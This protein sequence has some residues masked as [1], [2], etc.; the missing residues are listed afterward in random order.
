MV[1]LYNLLRGD[2]LPVVMEHSQLPAQLREETLELFRNGAAQVIVSARS[3]IEGFNVPEADL[4][5]IVA[6]SSSPR[7]RI[8]SIGRVLRTYRNQFGETKTSRVCIL[9]VRNSVDE[10][11]YER[12]DWDDL[13]GLDRNR[14]FYWNPPEEPL[15]VHS[16]PRTAVPREED[17][18]FGVLS[19]GDDYPG[20]Y[21]GK[22]FSSDSQGNVTD[23]EGQVAV[24]P[25]GIPQL[26]Q[27][28][29]GQPGRFRVTAKNSAVLVRVQAGGE[30]WTTVYGGTLA[31]PFEFVFE[32]CPADKVDIDRLVPGDPYP[33]PI[34]PADEYRFRQRRGGVITKRVTGGEAFAQ[35][36]D[37]DRLISALKEIRYSARPPTRI[38]VNELGHAF[39]RME[40]KPHFLAALDGQLDFPM[41]G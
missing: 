36:T 28:L 31:Q 17:I 14:Y 1:A 10:H 21:E 19:S 16:P 30:A 39:W 7:Q 35:G 5:I 18:D 12:E 20:R 26:V 34:R 32:S 6:S 4:G 2:G 3:L 8:Q 13:V 33:G 37:V 9:Y 23:L 24:N 41:E 25:Q 27:R 29:K 40:G 15:E 38:Y 11:I 22:E